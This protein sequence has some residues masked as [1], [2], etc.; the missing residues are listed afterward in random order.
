MGGVHIPR[1]RCVGCGRIAPKPALV[2]LAA[3]PSGH[4]SRPIAT[5][6]RAGTLPGRGAYVCRDEHGDAP[7][8]DCLGLAT[9]RG[10]LQRAFRRAVD[11]PS[12]LV[13]SESR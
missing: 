11:V 5:F 7:N 2:R 4:Q 6:D 10:V 12:E 13:E 8:H 9:G 3:V 1:R